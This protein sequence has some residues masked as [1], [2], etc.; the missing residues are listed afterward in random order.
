LT[1]LL[2]AAGLWY[3]FALVP[4]TKGVPLERIERNLRSGRKLRELAT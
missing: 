1:F 2:S 3:C 4:E